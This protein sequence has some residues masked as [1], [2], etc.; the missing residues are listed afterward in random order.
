MVN[1]GGHNRL[2]KT[3]ND[4]R[5]VDSDGTNLGT[6]DNR[7]EVQSQ[8]LNT[9]NIFTDMLRELKKINLHLSLMNDQ[10]IENTEVEA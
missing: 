8:D 9:F 6:E 4:V 10:I 5:L 1:G 7:L 2:Y 3:G